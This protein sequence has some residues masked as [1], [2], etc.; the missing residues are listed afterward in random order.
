MP[1]EILWAIFVVA[2]LLLLLLCLGDLRAHPPCG[3][4]HHRDLAE[5]PD[6]FDKDFND[7]ESEEEDDDGKEENAL[8]KNER[9]AK[10]SCWSTAKGVE[11][12]VGG[13]VRSRCACIQQ[14]DRHTAV[15]DQPSI[16]VIDVVGRVCRCCFTPGAAPGYM[17]S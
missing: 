13:I 11:E 14:A 3:A 2:L 12:G 1:A 16:Q 15:R 6:K 4:H 7:S 8:R 9:A 5:E 17:T 10:V